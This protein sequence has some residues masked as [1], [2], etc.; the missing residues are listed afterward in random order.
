[1]TN[2]YYSINRCSSDSNIHASPTK[3][4]F[5]EFQRSFSCSCIS[6]QLPQNRSIV[7]NSI[8]HYSGD[9]KEKRRSKVHWNDAENDTD[10]FAENSEHAHRTS[11][12]KRKK[13]KV[14]HRH[15]FSFLKEFLTKRKDRR[16]R[17]EAQ[18]QQIREFVPDEVPKVR[19]YE[20]ISASWKNIVAWCLL[21]ILELIIFFIL[22]MIPI[23]KKNQKDRSEKRF[24]LFSS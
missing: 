5:R 1:M 20:N 4:N 15:S 13:I 16:L 18:K 3:N 6:T 7:T 17:K 19:Q 2:F 22:I 24:R 11:S 23:W 12:K 14:V 9:Q 21:K 8:C 10:S